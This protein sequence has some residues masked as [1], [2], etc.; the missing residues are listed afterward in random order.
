[1]L[2]LIF[3]ANKQ[4]EVYLAMNNKLGEYLAKQLT[5]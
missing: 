3:L 5:T 1:M 2:K 4:M